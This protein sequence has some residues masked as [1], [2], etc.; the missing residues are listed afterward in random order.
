MQCCINPLSQGGNSGGKLFSSFRARGE[1]LGGKFFPGPKIRGEILKIIIFILFFSFLAPQAKFFS[2]PVLFQPWETRFDIQNND[3][4]PN[5]RGEIFLRLSG[6]GGEVRGEINY[7][8]SIQ[9][10]NFPP[11]PPNQGG[12]Y[13]TGGSIDKSRFSPEAIHFGFTYLILLLPFL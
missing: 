3:I 1:I 12:K 10:G 5:L 9:G 4:L 7:D 8:L 6:Q 11:F 13:N 2:I